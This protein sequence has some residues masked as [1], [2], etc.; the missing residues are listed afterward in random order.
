MFVLKQKH[1][2]ANLTLKFKG[3]FLS[4]KVAHKT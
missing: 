2:E 3:C 1:L 4:F